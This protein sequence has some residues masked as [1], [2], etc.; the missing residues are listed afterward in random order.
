MDQISRQVETKVLLAERIAA[1]EALAAAEK[2][3][4]KGADEI[5]TDDDAGDDDEAYAAWRLRELQRIATARDVRDREIKD[6]DE[7]EQWQQMSEEERQAWLAAHP[8]EQIEKPK[9]SWRFL[10]KYWHRG[11]FFQTEAEWKGE[12]APLVGD[13]LAARD[14]SLPT[15]EDRAD[16][17][18]L[19]QVMQVKNFGRRGQTKWTHLVAEDT[20][21]VEDPLWRGE[22]GG[23]GRSRT[24]GGPGPGDQGFSKPKRLKT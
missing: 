1:E 20:T 24:D 14:F 23:G 5:D 19:P 15:G 13:A 9:K 10:Q 4:P 22:G 21:R 18:M 16:R 3:G 6:A 11:A 8:K 12:E 7:R 17:S 2:D